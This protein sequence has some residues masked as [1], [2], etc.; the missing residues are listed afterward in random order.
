M[1]MLASARVHSLE[2][3]WQG[4]ISHGNHQ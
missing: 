3:P 2:T 1:A 4:Q